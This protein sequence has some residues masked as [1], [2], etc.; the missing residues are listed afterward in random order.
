MFYYLIPHGIPIFLFPR[1]CQHRIQLN[2]HPNLIDLVLENNTFPYRTST[3]TPHDKATLESSLPDII[4]EK[5]TVTLGEDEQVA[6]KFRYH[7]FGTNFS[8]VLTP[9]IVHSLPLRR[10]IV[11]YNHVMF[12]FLELQTAA[13]ETEYRKYYDT[14][15][16]SSNI[17]SSYS[18]DI[19]TSSHE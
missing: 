12:S 17:S 9:S 10:S 6:Q 2:N 14:K 7:V 3:T 8:R 13:I 4:R 5:P 16:Y 19:R 11:V 1:E 15:V 18:N